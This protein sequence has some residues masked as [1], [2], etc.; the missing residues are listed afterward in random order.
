M[1]AL[2]TL[3]LGTAVTTSSWRTPGR[4]APPGADGA[5]TSNLTAPSAS[6]S[7]PVSRWNLDATV[8]SLMTAEQLET[9]TKAVN[10]ATN[11]AVAGCSERRKH[12]TG[13]MKRAMNLVPPRSASLDSVGRKGLPAEALSPPGSKVAASTHDASRLLVGHASHEQSPVPGTT[14]CPQTGLA[15]SKAARPASWNL[16]VVQV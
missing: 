12:D 1:D 14:A 8:T 7:A 10:K 16:G 15:A 2:R 13:V 4:N 5:V 3:A 9:E 11:S 6:S